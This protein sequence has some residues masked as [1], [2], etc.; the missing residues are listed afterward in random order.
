MRCSCRFC[1]V[2]HLH[3]SRRQDKA[4]PN[5]RDNLL[6]PSC[7]T[8]HQHYRDLDRLSHGKTSNCY[9]NMSLTLLSKG[10]LQL[11]IFHFRSMAPKYAQAQNTRQI[12]SPQGPPT[13]G[14]S[15]WGI[16]RTLCDEDLFHSLV[17]DDTSPNGQNFLHRTGKAQFP[18][19]ASDSLQTRQQLPGKLTP[20]R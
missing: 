15:H 2:F 8:L 3:T 7:R 6:C 10:S 14:R 9:G 12:Q 1:V 11:P 5:L 17:L 19:T 20:A 13:I 4:D 16:P 18:T